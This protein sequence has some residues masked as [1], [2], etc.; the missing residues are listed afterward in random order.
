MV[1]VVLSV[2]FIAVIFIAFK[3]GVRLGERRAADKLM[4]EKVT[5]SVKK[6]F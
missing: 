3:E 6:V 1:F 5:S 2:L 4:N